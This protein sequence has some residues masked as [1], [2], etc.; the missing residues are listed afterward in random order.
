MYC[1]STITMKRVYLFLELLFFENNGI[2]GNVTFILTVIF[3][4]VKSL[5]EQRIVEK[6]ADSETIS[7]NHW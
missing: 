5:N 6:E 4:F 7:G 2:T 1:F 3:D